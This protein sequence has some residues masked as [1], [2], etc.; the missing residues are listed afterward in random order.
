MHLHRQLLTGKQQLHQQR[1][2][3]PPVLMEKVLPGQVFPA[4]AHHPLTRLRRHLRQCSPRKL[5]RLHHA[6]RPCQPRLAHRLRH[7]R[8]IGSAVPRPQVAPS[9][10]PLAE[11]WCQPERPQPITLQPLTLHPSP[12]SSSSQKSL[13]FITEK[14]VILTLSLPKGKNP[15]HFVL[16]LELNHHRPSWLSSASASTA[17]EPPDRPLRPATR[18]HSAC[19]HPPGPRA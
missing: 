7:P 9:P 4:R 12:Q 3:R 15:P 17:P 10:W 5:A 2:L 6:L 14:F 8:Y 11:P 13:S 16:A 18:L 1:K 19:S